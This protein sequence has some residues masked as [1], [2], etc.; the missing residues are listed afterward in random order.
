MIENE[1]QYKITKEQLEKFKIAL[2]FFN[3]RKAAKKVGMP[4]AKAQY[5]AFKSEIEILESQVKEYEGIK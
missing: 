3:I 1:L 2:G 5:D 4:L